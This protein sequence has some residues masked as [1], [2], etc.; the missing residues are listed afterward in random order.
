MDKREFV[1]KIDALRSILKKNGKKG[2][3]VSEF[4]NLCWLGIKRPN[5]LAL[6]ESVVVKIEI[7]LDDIFIIANNIEI[8]RIFNEEIHEEIQSFFSKKSFNWYLTRETILEFKKEDYLDDRLIEDEIKL[9]R[10]IMKQSD[11]EQSIL[12]GNDLVS[13]IEDTIGAIQKGKTEY[14]ISA[15]MYQLCVEK[16]IEVGLAL[17]ATNERALLYRHPIATR[18][19]INNTCLLALTARRQGIYSCMSRMVTL[20]EPSEELLRKRDAVLAVDIASHVYTKIGTPLNQVFEKIKET[21]K[22]YGFENEWKNHHQG[23]VTGYK[24]RE[25]K[26]TQDSDILIADNMM[27]AYNPSVPGYKTEDTFYLRNGKPMLTTFSKRL[28]VV[29]IEFEGK[30]YLKPDIIRLF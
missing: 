13:I 8:E 24:S 12:L 27:F 2:L 11:L 15:K 21:Y 1:E 23:G 17:C 19:S 18:A 26:I 7:T 28:P 4:A 22:I 9:H 10:M 6:S 3:L 5:V 14:E 30:T 25:E 20:S 16:S 29:E